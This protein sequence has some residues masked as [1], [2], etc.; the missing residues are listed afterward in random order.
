MEDELVQHRGSA[1]E[2]EN[3]E[4][5]PFSG[6]RVSVFQQSPN[7]TKQKY[8]AKI[9]LAGYSLLRKFL[10]RKTFTSSR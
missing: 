3:A 1:E 4:V 7:T 6:F 2:N 10:G 8:P 9:D 5:C